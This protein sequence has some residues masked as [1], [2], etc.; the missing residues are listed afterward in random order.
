MGIPDILSDIFEQ[1]GEGQTEN[2]AQMVG[3]RMDR[4]RPFIERLNGLKN[5]LGK[6][7]KRIDIVLAQ[8]ISHAIGEFDMLDALLQ[9]GMDHETAVKQLQHLEGELKQINIELTTFKR[10]HPPKGQ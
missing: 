9:E 1:V 7:F 10:E 6:E 8:K 2:P 4:A 3:R 5:E